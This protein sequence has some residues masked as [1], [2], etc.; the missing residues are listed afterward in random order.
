MTNIRVCKGDDILSAFITKVETRTE[1][2]SNGNQNTT[3]IEKSTSLERNNEPDYIKV[4]T[5]M[6]AEFNGVPVAYREF[7]LQLA[8]RMTYCNS[9]DLENAQLIYTGKPFSDSIMSALN[10]KIDMYN[11]GLRELVKANAIRRV[12]R[13]VYQINPQYIGKGE[14]KYNPRLNRGGVEDLIA[15]FNFK[16]K[17]VDTKIIWADDGEE[18]EMNEIYRNG[19]DVKESDETV[20]K[21]MLVVAGEDIKH[22]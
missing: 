4:Y 19:L 13:G 1:I 10:W 16:D 8:V 3:K 12:A 11:R 7:F 14:W 17:N 15:T 6:W 20:L 18:N 21:N 22:D 9:D 2:D 5:H